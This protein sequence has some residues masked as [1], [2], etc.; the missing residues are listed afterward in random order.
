MLALIEKNITLNSLQGIAAP[1]IYDWGDPPPAHIPQHPD[2]VLAA[3]C[4]Y[5]EPAFPLLL[6]TLKNLIG[7]Q[8]TCYFCFKK[9]RRADLHF[10]K[11]IKKM[12]HVAQ[13]EDDPDQAIYSRDSIF[14]CVVAGQTQSLHCQLSLITSADTKS[15]ENDLQDSR[16]H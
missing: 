10:I 16:L 9:R 6:E 15:R 13:V 7:E 4:V 3:D 14:L 2:V 1:S 5:F 11:S 8:T 12:F